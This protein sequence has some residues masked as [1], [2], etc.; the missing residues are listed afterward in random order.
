MNA[1]LT[2]LILILLPLIAG[3]PRTE[4]QILDAVALEYGLTADETHLLFAIRK[5]EN[6]RVGCE[7][8]IEVEEARR[9][10]N[11][12]EK[13]LETQ[14][15]WCA[16]TIKKRYGGDLAAFGA[17]YCPLNTE[18]WVYNVKYFMNRGVEQR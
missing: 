5:A 6:G 16:G 9:Y 3:S 10:A 8:G 4:P 15:R 12:F 2:Q 17:R 18:V 1:V 14:A 13:S 7:M 11:D